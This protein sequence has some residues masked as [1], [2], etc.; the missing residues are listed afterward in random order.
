MNIFH[1]GMPIGGTGTKRS[2]INLEKHLAK[3]RSII[4]IQNKDEMCLA[5]ALVF[6]IAKIE[7]DEQYLGIKNH[8]CPRRTNRSLWFGGS[9]TISE[10]FG[11]I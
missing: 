11:R 9:Q 1:V 10:L 5:R 2:E 3:K 4:R 8:R 7:N 6:S